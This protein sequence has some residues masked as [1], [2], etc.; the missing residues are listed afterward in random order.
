[1]DA[2]LTGVGGGGGAKFPLQRSA[3]WPGR[4]VVLRGVVFVDAATANSII[5]HQHVPLFSVVDRPLRSVC[6]RGV[7]L[8]E[9][10]SSASSGHLGLVG[11]FRFRGIIVPF[12]F[13]MGAPQ[14][15]F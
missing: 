14:I 15:D 12:Q 3:T 6:L 5:G 9:N 8:P 7:S 10:G 2:V 4:N 1:M 13:L 11:R